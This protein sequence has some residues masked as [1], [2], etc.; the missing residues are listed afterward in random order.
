[1]GTKGGKYTEEFKK[2]AVDLLYGP[3]NI[4]QGSKGTWAHANPAQDVAS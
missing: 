2:G 3:G 4:E 1:M